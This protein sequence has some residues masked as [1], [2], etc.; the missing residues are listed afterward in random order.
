MMTTGSAKPSPGS[1]TLCLPSK[2]LAFSTRSSLMLKIISLLEGE[3]LKPS[4]VWVELPRQFDDLTIS[5]LARDSSSNWMKISA[6]LTFLGKRRQLLSLSSIPSKRLIA[7]PGSNVIL[8]TLPGFL[9]PSFQTALLW[10]QPSHAGT[11][12][13]PHVE[14]LAPQQISFDV[15]GNWH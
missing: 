3:G 14:L 12:S 6:E 1:K 13:L 7:P 5:T 4:S 9:L 11:K 15:G 8:L 10:A 2:G